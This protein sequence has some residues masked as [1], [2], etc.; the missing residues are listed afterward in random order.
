MSRQRT[1]N[2]A[3]SA[4]EW[5]KFVK[6][7]AASLFR[8]EK[9]V[10]PIAN[11][12]NVMVIKLRELVV[13][14]LLDQNNQ[15]GGLQPLRSK[16]FVR[17]VNDITVKAVDTI[18]DE[19]RWMLLYYKG[20]QDVYAPCTYCPKRFWDSYFGRCL[21]CG[22]VVTSGEDNSGSAAEKGTPV[23]TT[24]KVD[25][26]FITPESPPTLSPSK[27][28]RS[29]IKDIMY[30]PGGAHVA[31]GSCFGVVVGWVVGC[32]TFLS[33]WPELLIYL[34]G[35][36]LLPVTGYLMLPMMTVPRAVRYSWAVVA[37]LII[38]L[39]VLIF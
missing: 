2:E 3:M 1:Y 18:L 31:T 4:A 22:R 34:V 13:Q 19:K 39:S 38:L 21:A 32:I 33:M 14:N 25:V 12:R 27:I 11:L 26:Q 37:I 24:D 20:H 10:K 23:G 8:T 6:T 36:T 7:N 15:F 30:G 28:T 16:N 17:A 29:Y 35:S 5:E 9:R